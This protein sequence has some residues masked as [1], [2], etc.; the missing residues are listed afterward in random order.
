MNRQTRVL[1]HAHEHGYYVDE[2]GRL[3]NARGWI[4]SPYIHTKNVC[5]YYAF[6]IR[7]HGYFYVHR[8]CAYQKFG[9]NMFEPGIQVRHK[10]SDSLDNTPDNILLGTPKENS[11]D[12]PVHRRGRPSKLSVE[13]IDSAIAMCETGMTYTQVAKEFGCFPGTIRW[14]HTKHSQKK[15][16]PLPA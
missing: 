13:Q 1:I 10:N 7:K 11:H 9:D 15:T 5:S 14:H 3:R 2:Q 4:L 6:R 12:I 8:L 16:A